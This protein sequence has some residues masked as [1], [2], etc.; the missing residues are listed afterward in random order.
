MAT[1]RCDMRR[2]ALAGITNIDQRKA[3]GR[4]V[5]CFCFWLSEQEGCC[6]EMKALGV[7]QRQ[8]LVGRY[9]AFLISMGVSSF[10]INTYL[11]PVKKA[12]QI[13]IDEQADS[14]GEVL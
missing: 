4:A 6:L 10:C 3:N 13:I 12:L 7:K 1:L 9:R 8:A 14:P 2:F 11:M 5:D